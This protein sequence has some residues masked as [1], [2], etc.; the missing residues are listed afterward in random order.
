MLLEICRVFLNYISHRWNRLLNLTYTLV[1]VQL[2]VLNS[3]SDEYVFHFC[4][5]VIASY[6]FSMLLFI[7][8]HN[9]LNSYVH[10]SIT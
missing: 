1:A 2:V 8:Q 9:T 7:T 4:V 5:I 10:L 6:L 3:S